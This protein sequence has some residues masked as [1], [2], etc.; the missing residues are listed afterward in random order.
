MANHRAHDAQ[1]V[2]ERWK[3]LATELGATWRCL[4]P[5]S[6]DV[7]EVG[8]FSLVGDPARPSI[9]LS[10]G[11][12]GDE[13]AGVLGLLG[14][15]E[16]QLCSWALG[17]VLIFPLLNPWGLM[18]NRRVDLTG[19][20]INR[21]FDSVNHPLVRAWKESLGEKKFAA[22]ICLHEDFDARGCYC[23]E[24]YRSNKP[25]FGRDAL[26]AACDEIPVD[27]S[28][29]IEGR[30]S[31]R[32]LLDVD[33]LPDL[34]EPGV[35]EAFPLYRDHSEVS[36]TFETPSEYSLYARVRAHEKFLCHVVARLR[37]R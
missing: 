12:H 3:A 24:I 34:D 30:E 18:N 9:Y 1:F 36:L 13:P 4:V 22:S 37:G 7:P 19:I 10:S 33:E 35:P 31:D 6:D 27:F 28:P 2:V 23:Y 25:R 21:I 15:A 20:D 29:E 16:S 26:E 5:A 8:V 17:D 14:W 32:G 11:V